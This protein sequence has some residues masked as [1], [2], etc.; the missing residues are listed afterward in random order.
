M[1]L[2]CFKV[3][4]LKPG[5]CLGVL[6]SYSSFNFTKSFQGCGSF[7]IKGSFSEGAAPL[8]QVGNLVYVDKRTAG[9]INAVNYSV[10]E[11][12][13]T[14][15]TIYGMELKGI[16]GYRIVWDTY[17]H[18]LPATKW[19]EGLVGA[20]TQGRRALFTSIQQAQIA[21]P[22][23]DRQTSYTNLSK[24]VEDACSAQLTTNGLLLGWDVI[25]DVDKGFTFTLVEGADRSYESAEPFLVSRDMDNLSTLEFA[26]SDKSIVNVVKCGGEGD[27]PARKFVTAGD[28]NKTGLER[29]EYFADKRQLQS[30]YTSADDGKQHQMTEEEYTSLL[31]QEAN[32]C[33]DGSTISMDAETTAVRKD[34]V[35]LL[36][37]KVTFLDRQFGVLADDYVTE[38]NIIDESQGEYTTLTVGKE[39]T[40]KTLVLP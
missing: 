22:N 13:A 33:L 2:Y 32:A 5:E 20:N 37:A 36:G 21:C 23:L 10:D 34:A 28:V 9:I 14:T 29:R 39:L 27:G 7:T 11:D 24:A 15:Y 35:P 6:D 19:I 3:D 12:G 16:L 17:N 30:S 18:N 26:V 4:G 8:L 31:T 40:A 38:I 1:D 25:C